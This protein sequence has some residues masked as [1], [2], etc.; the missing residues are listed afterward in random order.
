MLKKFIFIFILLLM[1]NYTYKDAQG[2]QM[3]DYT[4]VYTKIN[5]IDYL[6]KINLVL[7]ILD[8]VCEHR[9]EV[10]N[11]TNIDFYKKMNVCMDKIY[12][13]NNSTY[14]FNNK[15]T[16]YFHRASF[17]VKYSEK[18]SIEYWKKYLYITLNAI[19]AVRKNGNINLTAET[20]CTELAF[21]Y[22]KASDNRSQYSINDMVNYIKNDIELKN[23]KDINNFNFEGAA[24]SKNKDGRL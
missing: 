10:R 3:P 20:E 8:N 19:E 7:F 12:A 1:M 14:T 17:T 23:N 9:R 13:I 15:I 16:Y 6:R 24:I 11:G 18:E 22:L 5:D 21:K 2:K 4:E